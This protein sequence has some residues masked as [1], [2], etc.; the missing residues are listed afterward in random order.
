[1][2]QGHILAPYMEASNRAWDMMDRKMATMTARLEKQYFRKQEK[3]DEAAAMRQNM[4]A[5]LA[6][7]GLDQNQTRAGI[8]RIKAGKSPTE[9]MWGKKSQ[10]AEEF[11]QLRLEREQ[12][13]KIYKEETAAAKA[14]TQ[15]IKDQNQLINLHRE[16]A[17]YSDERDPTWYLPESR[18]KRI[19]RYE[20][21]LGYVGDKMSK[22]EYTKRTKFIDEQIEK[23]NKRVN[24]RQLGATGITGTEAD[25]LKAANLHMEPPPE[26]DWF[27]GTGVTEESIMAAAKAKG[28]TPTQSTLNQQPLVKMPEKK[29]E[30]SPTEQA[31]NVIQ[32]AVQNGDLNQAEL[33]A[34]TAY[35]QGG[36]DL[37]KVIEKFMSDPDLKKYVK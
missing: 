33:D 11:A 12:Q 25:A 22:S 5:F 17:R 20:S 35:L 6:A 1:M 24:E 31:I 14:E 28:H 16:R 30:L 18:E 29:V 10:F 9:W 23:I 26:P 15:D 32:Q 34:I 8:A 21:Q 7:P 19:Y 13:A 36:G 27:G 37:S 4:E 2:A 3:A